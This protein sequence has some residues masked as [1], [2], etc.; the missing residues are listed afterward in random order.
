MTLPDPRDK[1][2]L[3]A[4]EAAEILG[5]GRSTLYASMNAGEIPFIQLG[6]RRIIPTAALLKLLGHD[7][8]TP[9]AEKPGT[10]ACAAGEMNLE[11][12]IVRPERIGTKRGLTFFCVE[13]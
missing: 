10:R 3:T 11:G 2:T 4:T 7:D 8:E 1:P 13:T 5:V 9:A 12:R 6:A